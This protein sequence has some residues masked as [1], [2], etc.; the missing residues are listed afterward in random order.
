[1]KDDDGDPM[2]GEL[3]LERGLLRLRL[4]RSRTG[5][6]SVVVGAGGGG[7][8]VVVGAVSTA[9]VSVA[10][11]S[12]AASWSSPSRAS[13][14][15]GQAAHRECAEAR[16]EEAQDGDRDDYGESKLLPHSTSPIGTGGR[17]LK[18]KGR[19]LPRLFS[20]HSKP[21][22][23]APEVMSAAG[24]AFLYIGLADDALDAVRRGRRADDVHV[25]DAGVVG[26]VAGTADV[27]PE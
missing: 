19:G 4:R 7:A 12:T 2:L 16:A 13:T 27:R 24:P 8:V 15:G 5:A 23:Q 1:M 3:L 9:P 14:E 11:V 17:G 20:I 10:P 6:A 18:E 22:W 25:L 26:R 21:V